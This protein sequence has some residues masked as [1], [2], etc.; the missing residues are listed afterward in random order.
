MRLSILLTGLLFIY[1][2][3]IPAEEGSTDLILPIYSIN[4]DVDDLESL[5][6]DPFEDIYYPA[7]FIYDTLIY[8]CEVRFRGASSRD[9]PK[10]S[11]KVK[12]PSD[13]NY[14][15]VE[16]LNLNAEYRD[17]TLMRNY[18]G[19]KLYNHI[20]QP[21]S[22]V[23]F[24]NVK[25]NGELMGLFVSIEQVDENFLNRYDMPPGALYKGVQ[26][27][28]NMSPILSD[29]NLHF[30]WEPK[31]TNQS[32]DH[33]LKELFNKFFFLNQNEFLS[34]IEQLIDID[35]FIDHFASTFSI[36]SLDNF[37]KNLYLHRNPETGLFNVF[38]WDNDAA[39]GN[40][41]EGV[42]RPW[43]ADALTFGMLNNQIIFRRL[44]ENDKWRTQFEERV[45]E[46]AGEGFTYLR[47]HVDSVFAAIFNDY[48]QDPQKGV[49]QEEILLEMANLKSFLTKRQA[50]LSTYNLPANNL[51]SEPQITNSF[52]IP[53]EDNIEVIIRSQSP[54]NVFFHYV[55]DLDPEVWND[56]FELKELELFDDGLHNDGEANDL[57]YGNTL[58]VNN[59]PKELIPGYFVNSNH[60]HYPW[61]GI[62]KINDPYN[63][64]ISLG[65]NNRNQKNFLGDLSI[66]RIYQEGDNYFIELYN[67]SDNS[68]DLSGS[69]L[70]CDYAFQTF[71][72]PENTI[73]GGN[74]V[75]IIASNKEMASL[76]FPKQIIIG[77][78]VFP[79]DEGSTIQLLTPSM[80]VYLDIYAD[81]TP[82]NHK[83][84]PI[85]INEIFYH[86]IDESDQSDWVELYNPS[87]EVIDLSDWKFTDDQGNDPF[88]FPEETVVGAWQYL[89]LC[90]ET[91]SFAQEYPDVFE[92]IGDF[93][94][95]LNAG[96]ELIRLLD[97]YG[98][99]IDSVRYDDEEPWPES[100]DGSGASLE[101]I[102][103][104]LDNG[105]AESWKASVTSGTPGRINSQY[106]G[107]EPP[108][109]FLLKLYNAYPNPFNDQVSINLSL[110]STSFIEL[111]I[112][113]PLGEVVHSFY[114]GS[115]I[116]G[117]HS[118]HWSPKSLGSG[119]YFVKLQLNNSDTMIKR[120][121]YIK[122]N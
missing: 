55:L 29:D 66:D 64:T 3:P 94:F 81:L 63:R 120:L 7:T 32:S 5:Y 102:N 17:P 78:F 45:V 38:P 31:I 23:D 108:D 110:D 71:P 83:H 41:W 121:M 43:L 39:F 113:N 6:E 26:H 61:N 95:N 76:L 112:L 52:A 80:E 48:K 58:S 14:F 33:Y 70:R 40:T 24:V 117:P 111:T 15:G 77:S 36:S 119:I 89:V 84:D 99:L 100:A 18:L 75:I 60:L 51:L 98:V 122:E 16:K 28:A 50:I 68:L 22:K 82:L 53:V 79:I 13:N 118:F 44:M 74:E 88:I 57:V 87:N 19:M 20:G 30:N 105:L 107:E 21:A 56:D 46:I 114:S 49:S 103:P 35:S 85:V 69:F 86:P 47:N 10:K 25:I 8:S 93:R 97:K 37:T 116:A 12:F 109:N 27:G 91:E 62:I 67:Q 115:L 92:K 72:F 34:Q 96:G 42:Y 11:W 4:I 59:L 104:Y 106:Q 54:Q 2:W 90:K 1:C 9:L 73:L 101:L 65:I